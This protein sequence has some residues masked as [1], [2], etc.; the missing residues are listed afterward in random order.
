MVGAGCGLAGRAADPGD[1]RESAL[2]AELDRFVPRTALAWPGEDVL[3]SGP[4]HRQV[5]GTLVF[6]DVSGFTALS[7]RLAQRGKVGA[8]QL[9]DVL[10]AVFGTML[11]LA[12]ARGGSLLK[13][14]GDALFLLFTG[15][16]H[17][18]AA[19]CAAVEMR[20]S[21]ANAGAVIPGGRLHLRMSVGVHA[22]SVD[23]FLVG[24]SHRELVVSGPATTAVAALEAAASAGQILVGPRVAEA[25][26]PAAVGHEMGPGRLLR[27]RTP[28]G[29]PPAP[30]SSAER[31]PRAA[32]FVPRAL[33]ELLAAGTVESEHRTAG[34]AFLR[35][36]GLDRLLHERGPSTVAEALHTLVSAAQSAA[37]EQSVTFLATD[38]AEDGGKIIL[39]AGFPTTADDDQGRLLRAAREVVLASVHQS[40]PLGVEAGVNRGHVFA[41]AVGSS[42]RATVTVMGD[43]VN[44]AARVM[45]K[46]EPGHVLATP[47]A[48]DAAQTLFS[49]EAVEPFMVKGKSRPVTAYEVSDEQGAR[50]PRGMGALPY[51]G[52]ER[53]MEVVAAALDAVRQGHGGVLEVSGDVGIGKTRLL[54]E[55][56]AG[57]DDLAVMSA[58]AEPYGSATP[59]RPV[60]D[61]LRGLLGLGASGRS[62]AEL[63][64]AMRTAVLD[65]DPTLEPL[66]PLV[67]DVLSIPVPETEVTRDLD[68]QFR[69][70]RIADTVVRLLAGRFDT[71]LVLV[72]DD[73][74]YADGATVTLLERIEREV[75][76]RPWLVVLTRRP[77][78]TGFTPMTSTSLVL[79]PLDPQACRS[80]VIAG[81]AA[82]PLRPHEVEV[83]VARVGGNPLFLEELLRS[84]REH[85]DLESMPSSLEGLVA[86]QVDALSPVARR[87]VRRASVLGRS[88]RVSVLEDLLEADE[89]ALTM[90]M[91]GELAETLEDD[92]QGRLRFRHALMRDAA[93]DSLPYRQ[94]QALH[95]Q[96]AASTERLGQPDPS[97]FA[98]NLALHYWMGGDMGQTWRWARVA[99][100]AARSAYANPVAMQQYERALRAAERVAGLDRAEVLETWLTMGE[101]AGLAGDFDKALWAYTNARR[102]A[103]EAVDSAR[104]LLHRARVLERTARYRT[105]LATLTRALGLVADTDRGSARAL[106]AEI[107]AFRAQVLGEQ[108]RYSAAL[109][110]AESAEKAARACGATAALALA[111]HWKA[112]ALS[113]L[114]RGDPEPAER[115]AVAL[116]EALGDL[117][118]L[119]RA[120]N[121][122]GAFAFFGGDWDAALEAYG[123]SAELT[124]RLGNEVEAATTDANL[125]EILVLQHRY[126]EADTVLT[127]AARVQRAAG[128]VDGATFA[129]TQLARA[130]AALGRLDEAGTMLSAVRAELIGLGQPDRAL[131]AT[132]A[133][134]E[135]ALLAGGRGEAAARAAIAMLQEAQSMAREET[136]VLLPQLARVRTQALLLAGHAEQARL[137]RATGWASRSSSALTTSGRC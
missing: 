123:R 134:A 60:R 32:G 97:A 63:A 67:G 65:V 87:V 93:Y 106:A 133:A 128:Y 2:V 24:G 126:A 5:D 79:E 6:I 41:G 104:V 49:T 137:S 23:L 45:A 36:Q 88:F 56:L 111:L 16:D 130:R 30:A 73:V 62:P 77:N 98:D 15:E 85:G 131:E 48:L 50:P 76:D 35:Y 70:Q 21:L 61:P 33:R 125:G 34:I 14:G 38:L 68:P 72:L 94:R 37:D 3:A 110:A 28:H 13:F 42:E 40:W 122:L 8:E 81:T 91:R 116:Y 26:G 95:L 107:E 10:N 80:L 119:Q 120:T 9:T 132:V 25:L 59:Y 90:S 17:E 39:V 1:I 102:W 66:L 101:V 129:E 89:A 55:S 69:P 75:T 136:Q 11:D 53:A 127:D 7:E 18:R 121:N 109:A 57:L 20:S 100:D 51:L 82:T 84:L 105:S 22:G 44:L 46:A 64:E 52:R 103:P 99:G 78:S 83:V 54:R 118:A 96:A 27:W 92:G 58:R 135:V 47:A 74:H 113:M 43:P 71:P 124:R 12:A 115:E 112:G 108:D 117:G 19:A 86:A 31:D 29:P 4:L 114:G